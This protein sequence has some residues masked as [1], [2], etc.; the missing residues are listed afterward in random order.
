MWDPITN[1]VIMINTCADCS[2][3]CKTCT[4]IVWC[5]ECQDTYEIKEKVN[6]GEVLGKECTATCLEGFFRD[7]TSE[8]KSC[9]ACHSDC[10]TCVVNN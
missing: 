5:T 9:T 7:A 6:H 4:D 1:L 8:D 2:A 10:K 3:Y